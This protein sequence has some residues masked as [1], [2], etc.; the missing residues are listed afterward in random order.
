[1]EEEPA[2][3][4][5][6]QEIPISQEKGRTPTIIPETGQGAVSVSFE[7][8]KFKP[9]NF[10]AGN[11]AYCY[12][13]WTKITSDK[14]LLNIVKEGYA[15]EFETEPCAKCNRGAIKF[16]GKDKE[17][18][19]E[20]LHKLYDKGVIEQSVHEEGEVL[21]NIFTR[22]KA[23]GSHRLILNLSRLNDHLEKL[24]FKMETFRSAL[25]LV[26]RNCYFA[27]I[28]LKD[29]YY[30][31]AID[32]HSRKYLKFKWNGCLFQFTCLA[33]GLSPAPRIYTK[34]L[35]PVFSTL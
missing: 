32:M 27:K 22:P 7:N 3:A 9:N 26:K 25:Q 10:K 28:D 18:I 23:D 4:A 19:N 24:H 34:L 11:I 17:I 21:S 30:S 5:G 8:L 12:N 33:N 6:T 31:V 29:A 14:T 35:K 15:I 1:M 16:N 13:N 20:L 2:T